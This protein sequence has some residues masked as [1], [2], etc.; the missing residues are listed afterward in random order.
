MKL[1]S[2]QNRAL[3]LIGGGNY[4]DNADF[5]Y[6]NFYINSKFIYRYFRYNLPIP[7][8]N[9]FIKNSDIS[10]CFTRSNTHNQMI[11][12]IPVCTISKMQ[13]CMA[14]FAEFVAKKVIFVNCLNP[15]RQF[16]GYGRGLRVLNAYSG[17]LYETN[18]L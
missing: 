10:N 13:R 16:R 12:N 8:C 7:L 9:L 4:Q 5:Y 3:R 11:F 18:Y 1:S 15:L 6:S 17:C 2:L 14:N